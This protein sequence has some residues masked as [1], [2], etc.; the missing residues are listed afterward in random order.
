MPQRLINLRSTSYE[1]PFDKAA[2]ETLRKIPLFEKVMDFTINWTNIKFRVIELCGSNFHVTK[3]SCPELYNLVHSVADTLDVDRMPLIYTQW[4]YGINAYTTGFKDNALLVVYTGAVDLLKDPELI[5]IVGHEMGHIKSGH[6]LYHVMAGM[7]GQILSSMG[8]VGSLGMPLQL[9]LGYWN[10]MSEFTADRAG[11]LA[12]QDL[13]AALSAIMKMAGIPKR[14]FNTADPHI[15]ARQAQEF[16]T[17][18]GDTANTI[19]RNISILDDSHPWLVLRASE[20]IK[21]VEDGGY[22]AILDGCEGIMCPR[23]NASV[24]KGLVKCP[25]CGSALS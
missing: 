20:L 9:A 22:Q 23:C 21:W 16:L 12:C 13:D 14:Y 5:Y 10:R 4:C 3:D 7:I 18:Y 2:L 19:I 17:R 15:F 8:I 11:L 1:H 24:E 25:V 6:V